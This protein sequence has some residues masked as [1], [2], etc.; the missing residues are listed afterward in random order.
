MPENVNKY[1]VEEQMKKKHEFNVFYPIIYSRGCSE[2][3][4]EIILP[5]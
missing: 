4:L 3:Y 1:F 2:I 5:F